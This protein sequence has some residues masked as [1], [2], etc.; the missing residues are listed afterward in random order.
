MRLILLPIVI[1]FIGF[2]SGYSQENKN[3]PDSQTL[4]GLYLGQTPPGMSP[5]VFAPNIITPIH[6][7]QN[8]LTISPHGKEIYWGIWYPEKNFISF[9]GDLPIRMILQVWRLFG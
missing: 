6:E 5:V 1:I 4:T 7:V 2:I 8:C 3:N 9:L